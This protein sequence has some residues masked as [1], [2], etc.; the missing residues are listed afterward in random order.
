MQRRLRARPNPA[1]PTPRNSTLWEFLL[2]G[3]AVCL[4]GM[5]YVRSP[6]PS[7]S[8]HSASYPAPLCY[9]FPSE[10]KGSPN[11]TPIQLK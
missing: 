11:T 5:V 7:T 1:Q 4:P 9:G 10:H 2:S 8:R 6:T 3:D